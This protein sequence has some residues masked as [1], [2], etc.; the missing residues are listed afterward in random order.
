MRKPLVMGIGNP[1]LQDDRAGIEVVEKLAALGAPCDTLEVYTVGFEIIDRCMGRDNVII[2][3]ACMLGNEPGSILDV[4]VDDIFNT[5]Y[6]ANSH[7]ITLGST[8]KIG[9][10]LFPDDMPQNLRIFLI[11]A[12]DVNE[13]SKQCSPEVYHAIDNVVEQ[14]QGVLASTFSQ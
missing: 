2:V 4:G 11:E 9:Y 7:A 8:L 6:L 13:F 12:K 5:A 3:D 14:I 1:L 10:K